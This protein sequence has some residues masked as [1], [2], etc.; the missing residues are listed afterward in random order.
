MSVFGAMTTAISGLSSQSAAFSNIGNDLAN[1]QT[2]G[3]KGIDTTFENYVTSSTLQSNGSSAVVARPEYTNTTQ[4]TISQTANPLDLALSGQGFFPVSIPNGSAQ[5]QPT[6]N[7]QQYY[8]REGD[9][10]LDHNNYLVNSTGHVLNTWPIN[11]AGEVD[12]TQIKPLQVTQGAYAPVP[13]STAGISAN[14]PATPTTTPY[15]VTTELPVYD[16]LGSSHNLDLKW[17]T[18]ATPNVW[19]LSIA[20]GATTIGSVNVAFG[21]AST[22]PVPEGTIGSVTAAGPGLTPSA[23]AAGQQA[24]VSFATTLGPASQPI[25]L[26]LGTFGGTNGVTQF[27]GSSYNLISLTQNGIEPGAFTGVS[28]QTNGNL[29]VNYDNGQSRVVGQ[30]PV[31]TFASADALQM[32]DGQAY[33]ATKDSGTPR[34]N[35]A[36]SNGAG[37]LVTSS[38]EGSNVDIAS[39]FTKLIVAQRAYSAN[40]KMVTT[41]DELLQQTIDMKR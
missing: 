26:N 19:S 2:T 34:A 18:T 37:N 13:T 28:A 38:L 40:T 36:G 14:L 7:G 35:E 41:A 12:R 32:H 3:Y 4:G 16:S 1:T 20:N 6:F 15:S 10:K 30:I 24:T 33:T 39:E 31:V 8:T 23:Y 11:A 27:A 22:N 17:S 5:G 29:T 25:T 9:F 21:S